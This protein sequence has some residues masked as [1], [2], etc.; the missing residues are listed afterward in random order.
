MPQGLILYK[1]FVIIF[2]KEVIDIAHIVKC[3][4]C[5]TKFDRDKIAFVMSGARRYAHASC[6]LREAAAEEKPL[7]VEI[8]DPNDNVTCK[9]CKKIFNKNKEAYVQLS[10]SIYAHLSCSELE[11]KRE[12]TVHL[13]NIY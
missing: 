3:S 9:Y 2:I 5:D 7:E 6:A 12:K 1:I 4:I 8:L 10:N 13:T 11:A